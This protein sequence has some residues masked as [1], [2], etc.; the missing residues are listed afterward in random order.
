M[1]FIPNGN[2]PMYSAGCSGVSTTFRKKK[3][4]E[5]SHA[6]TPGIL[7]WYALINDI[8][9]VIR[10]T[11][12]RFISCFIGIVLGIIIPYLIAFTD[13]STSGRYGASRIEWIWT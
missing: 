4:V 6:P 13:A 7:K 9:S 1:V 5:M 8:I 12:I 11:V 3:I 10:L 2:V